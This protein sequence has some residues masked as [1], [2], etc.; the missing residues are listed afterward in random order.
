MNKILLII[1]ST[2]LSCLILMLVLDCK[3]SGEDLANAREKWDKTDSQN[4]LTWSQAT[5]FCKNKQMRLP[6]LQ[7][8]KNAYK[9]GLAQEWPGSTYWSS[10][11]VKGINYAYVYSRTNMDYFESDKTGLKDT[12]CIR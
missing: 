8:L 1:K 4:F 3:K 9:I 11:E 6:T 2:L 5:E 12:H 10:E 7:E